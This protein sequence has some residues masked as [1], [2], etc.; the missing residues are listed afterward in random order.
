MLSDAKVKPNAGDDL[1][2]KFVLE[3]LEAIHTKKIASYKSI[4]KKL[5]PLFYA[6]EPGILSALLTEEPNESP[7][8]TVF[9]W[10]LTFRDETA[11]FAHATYQH[12]KDI[13]KEYEDADVFFRPIQFILHGRATPQVRAAFFSL[14]PTFRQ[15]LAGF[16]R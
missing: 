4:V 5:T 7:D 16:I 6:H 12:N 11:L 3:A 8:F 13:V 15:P 9:R 14:M 1:G 2:G 10:I